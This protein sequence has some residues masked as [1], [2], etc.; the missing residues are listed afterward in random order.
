MAEKQTEPLATTD[1]PS[2]LSRLRSPQ[3]AD[4]SRPRKIKKNS[5]TD[6]G[7]K[8]S[9]VAA[10]RSKH[11]PKSTTPHQRVQEFPG[12]NFSVSAGKLFCCGCREELALKVSTIRLHVKSRKHQSGKER[13]LRS[14]ASERDIATSFAKYN[15]QEHTSGETLP[16]EM[17]V[18]RIRVVTAFLK[19]GV[20]LSKIEKFRDIL[21]EH[22]QQLAGRRSLSDLIPFIHEEEVSHLRRELEGKKVSVIFDG[23]TRV[24]EAMVIVL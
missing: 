8:R 24:G 3:P 15:Q 4:I 10:S 13:R 9:Q 21:E 16:E 11:N 23:T 2:L 22:G 6:V 20:P 7:N 14:E 12:E 1:P 17:Q 5:P 19:A 18:Y